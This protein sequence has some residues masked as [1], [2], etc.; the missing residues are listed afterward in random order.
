MNQ[1]RRELKG[2]DAIRLWLKGKDKWNNYMKSHADTDVSFENVI[3]S[4]EEL[5]KNYPNDVKK[6]RFIDINTG[7]FLVD[8]SGFHFP[9][10]VKFYNSVLKGKIEFLQTTFG[11]VAN[12]MGARFEGRVNFS[13]AQFSEAADFHRAK[14]Q[15]CCFFYGS[16]FSSG[17]NFIGTEFMDDFYLCKA[18]VKGSASFTLA[19]FD[20]I[21]KFDE[22]SFLEDCEF[23]KSTF[24]YYVSFT[25]CK[26]TSDLIFRPSDTIKI[27][28]LNFN[29]TSFD[30]L[31]VIVGDFNCIPDLRQT[32]TSHHIDLSAVSINLKRH[33]S[34]RYLGFRKV[35]DAGDSE[36][37]CRLKELAE[38][39]KDHKRAL[40]FYADELRAS[41]WNKLSVSQSLLDCMYSCFSN[42]GQ[43]IFRPFLCLI[44]LMVS[45]SSIIVSYSNSYHSSAVKQAV[46]ISVATV[47]PFISISKPA[48]EDALN[49]LFKDS[50]QVSEN[51]Y[52]FSY[53]YALGSF[54]FIF[55][56][57]LGL[58]NRFRL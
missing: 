6:E 29:G 33:F 25:D 39:N 2:D 20:S 48:R 50:K 56:I 4:L 31:F 46:I 9:G 17:V 51:Y 30:K 49:K 41:R 16:E 21:A 1:Q 42:Y 35:L 14:F 18:K 57:G 23:I 44:I 26:F 11:G 38:S 55:L 58:R 28:T 37:L 24:A 8:F 43:S 34:R 19:K 22:S 5:T 7:N 32:K 3:F 47:T 27:S 12:F 45:F 15:D 13:G 53:L 54:I 40:A 52:L 10:F 36:R